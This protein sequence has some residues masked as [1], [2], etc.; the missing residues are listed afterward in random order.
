MIYS[1]IYIVS[2]YISTPYRLSQTIDRHK[3]DLKSQKTDPDV[4]SEDFNTYP[5]EVT[6]PIVSSRQDRNNT[7]LSKKN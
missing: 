3:S 6:L 7:F 4:I 2:I 5:Q 1:P